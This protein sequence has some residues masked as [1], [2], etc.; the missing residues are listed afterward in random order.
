MKNKKNR[1]FSLLETLKVLGVI[2]LIVISFISGM[3]FAE[4]SYLLK[5]KTEYLKAEVSPPSPPEVPENPNV[6]VGTYAITLNQGWN[7]VG[8]PVLSPYMSNIKNNS[9]KLKTL[10]NNKIEIVFT[11]TGGKW[12]SYDFVNN[13]GNLNKIELGRGYWIKMSEGLNV[14]INSNS[15]GGN[16]DDEGDDDNSDD[17]ENL[18]NTKYNSTSPCLPGN[19]DFS[20]LGGYNNSKLQDCNHLTPKYIAGRE[21]ITEDPKEYKPNGKTI[22]QMKEK[23]N[24]RGMDC[25]VKSEDKIYCN[26]VADGKR[27]GMIDIIKDF[28]GNSNWHWMPVDGGNTPNTDDVSST[29]T[30]NPTY[31][32]N[33]PNTIYSSYPNCVGIFAN[34]MTGYDISKLQNC[35]HLTPKYVAGRVF[36]SENVTEYG[37]N[38]KK[39][40]DIVP[41]LNA[42]GMAC[43]VVSEDKIYCND[44]AEGNIVRTIDII[45]DFGGNSAWQWL[46]VNESVNQNGLCGTSHQQTFNS[47]P[48]VN[49]CNSGTPSSISEN[50]NKFNWSCGGIGT[51]SA[52]NCW[53]NKS[54]SNQEASCGTSNGQSFGSV[55]SN[56]LCSIGTPSAVAEE[57]S[58]FQWTCNNN[59]RSVNCEANK[60][61]SNVNG[62]CGDITEVESRT[63][64]TQAVACKSGTLD[65]LR[66]VNR[67]ESFTW[68]CKG[69]GNGSNAS[70]SAIKIIL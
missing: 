8:F 56:N 57:N 70:C 9:G 31:N 17:G 26:D 33:L 23:L 24:S 11:Y 69:S 2:F 46:P 19:P 66:T 21:F 16:D 39:A 20:R 63:E 27:V 48:T 52:T 29:S 61:V 65:S 5:L 47:T 28:G 45:R 62:E 35:N 40:L 68:I 51:G 43:T 64:I 37:P 30:S 60:G 15:T 18:P 36:S 14:T 53:A 25:S 22:E 50:N 54:N 49:L 38:G 58:K 59:G 44:V 7:L 4:K 6:G 67:G 32:D 1:Q 34:Q 12:E 41:K 3:I 55:P 42:K 10:F 13:V